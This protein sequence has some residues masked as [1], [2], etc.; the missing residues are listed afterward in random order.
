MLRK[1]GLFMASRIGLL[2][3]L[4]AIALGTGIAVASASASAQDQ[5]TFAD[6]CSWVSQQTSAA[7]LRSLI[8]R[9]SNNDQECIFDQA[10]GQSYCKACITLAAERLV[11]LTATAAGPTAAT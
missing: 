1:W 6:L 9:L 2:R 7:E 11:T 5:Q 10:T 8:S 3:T 4:S